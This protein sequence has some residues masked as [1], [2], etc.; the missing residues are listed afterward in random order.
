MLQP[1]NS[2]HRRLDRFPAWAADNGCYAAGDAFDADAWLAWLASLPAGALFATAPDVVGDAAATLDRSASYLPELR[3]LGFPAA[4]AAQNGLEELSVPWA[5]FDVLFIGGSPECRPCRFVRASVD[6]RQD[7]PSCGSPLAEWKLSA[8]AHALA[9]EAHAR[10]KTVHMG[11]VNTKQRIRLAASWRCDSVDGTL[12]AFGARA[13]L[14]LL[15]RWLDQ[16]AS[17]Q[18]ALPHA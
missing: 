18:L 11:R 15:V 12:L 14:P 4:L 9:Q 5:S 2:L 7:C 6:R 17:T 10:G 16:T 3:R 13:N 1:G 8:E